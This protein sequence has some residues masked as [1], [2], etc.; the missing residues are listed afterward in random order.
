MTAKLLLKSA[1]LKLAMYVLDSSIDRDARNNSAS[2]SASMIHMYTQLAQD[3]AGAHM[4]VCN[5]EICR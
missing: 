4:I 5:R 3:G 1:S 2:A